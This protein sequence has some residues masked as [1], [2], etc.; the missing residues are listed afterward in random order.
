MKKTILLA[1]AL[2]SGI[3][4]A[5]ADSTVLNNPANKP[6]FGA[7]LSVESSIPGDLQYANFKESVYKPGAGVSVGLVYN[8]PIV[9]NFYVE[10]GVE[11]YYDTQKMNIDDDFLGATRMKSHSG[12]S[13]GMR[14]PV[15]LGYHFDFSPKV[16]LAVFTGP[17]LNVGFSNDY[18]MTSET[19]MVAGEP[20]RVHESGSL[21][22]P[23]PYT[24]AGID[25]Q[26]NRVNA[27]WRIGV[28]VN[29]LKNYYVGISGDLG[30]TNKIKHD[31]NG[32][33]NQKDNLFQLT[34]GY[35]F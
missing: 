20:V 21:Y 14:V 10:P 11:F 35:N 17:V 32:A 7:R 9:A 16:N 13:F 34:L 5:S 26:F 33:Y 22:N 24:G 19:A 4:I 6:Y 18:Y 8:Q 1:M 28:G 12:R 3:G 2:L 23:N 29:F 30:L 31:N 25:N 15:M 27:A